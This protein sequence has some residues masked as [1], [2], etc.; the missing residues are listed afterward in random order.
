VSADV[1][2]Q[3]PRC[4]QQ[5]ITALSISIFTIITITISISSSS[6]V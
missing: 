4:S 3:L 6:A 5:L 1:L 2:N